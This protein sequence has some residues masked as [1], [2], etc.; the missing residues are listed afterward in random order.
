MFGIVDYF[1]IYRYLEKKGKACEILSG[2][3]LR[4]KGRSFKIQ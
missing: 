4:L 1:E 3:E 2:I